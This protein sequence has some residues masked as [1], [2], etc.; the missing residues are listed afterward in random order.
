MTSTEH[1]CGSDRLVE[2]LK[3]NEDIKIAVNVQRKILFAMM[4]AEAQALAYGIKKEQS[5][6]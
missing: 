2:V 1:K 3:K 6:P 4:L 5:L